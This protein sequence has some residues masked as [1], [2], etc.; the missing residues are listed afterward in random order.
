MSETAETITVITGIIQ[1]AG[2][3][4]CVFFAWRTDRRLRTEGA[5]VSTSSRSWLVPAAI[6]GTGSIYCFGY[7]LYLKIS[8]SHPFLMFGYL[9]CACL[10]VVFLWQLPFRQ[11]GTLPASKQ[12]TPSLL[13]QTATPPLFTPLQIELLTLAKD[14]QGFM[15]EMGEKP[16]ARRENFGNTVEGLAEY[17][18]A[19]YVLQ[20]PWTT[21]LQ[22]SY[23]KHYQQRLQGIVNE[24]GIHGLK[25]GLLDG[26][27]R[28]SIADDAEAQLLIETLVSAAY[29]LDDIYVFPRNVYSAEKISMMAESEIQQK[30]AWEPGFVV[31]YEQYRRAEALK[32][33]NRE[34]GI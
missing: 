18:Q 11:G 6:L 34:V 9:I 26:C 29:Q 20:A 31:S 21:Q 19:D 16:T 15:K 28:A 2:T 32:G 7:F 8:A 14:L 30:L 23:N 25:R 17:I 24:L 4:L 12:L 10:G 22:S 27:A 5:F 3:V 1:S 33:R 13:S